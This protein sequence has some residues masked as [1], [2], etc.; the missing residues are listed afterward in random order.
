MFGK[1]STVNDYDLRFN[2]TRNIATAKV[3]NIIKN[4]VESHIQ[5]RIMRRADMSDTVAATILA[6]PCY[7]AL[8]LN[9]GAYK[10]KSP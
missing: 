3:P 10:V 7:P 8:Q 9:G 1:T 6:I 5:G 4:A 2:H